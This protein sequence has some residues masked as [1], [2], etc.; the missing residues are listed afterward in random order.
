ME[1]LSKI[2][3][4]TIEKLPRAGKKIVHMALSSRPTQYD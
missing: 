3:L 2:D 4:F 1:K